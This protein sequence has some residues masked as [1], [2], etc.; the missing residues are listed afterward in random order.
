A[1]MS[2]QTA[3]PWLKKL[4]LYEVD[5]R[6]GIMVSCAIN[7]IFGFPNLE[8]ILIKDDDPLLAVTS[9]DVDFSRMGQLQLRK[10]EFVSF[11]GLQNEECMRTSILH[12]SPFLN[13]MDISALEMLPAHDENRISSNCH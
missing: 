11:G 6:N 1:E 3:L 4:G 9:T 2:V 13:E 10:V 8:T 7:L 12:R 5:F